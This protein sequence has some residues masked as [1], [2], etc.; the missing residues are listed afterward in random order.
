MWKMDAS[1]WADVLCIG[2][3]FELC[4]FGNWTLFN[5]CSSSSRT[6]ISNII[7]NI[8]KDDDGG[9][10]VKDVLSNNQM[11]LGIMQFA[12]SNDCVFYVLLLIC[13]CVCMRVY[14]CARSEC[15]RQS[16]FSCVELRLSW[17]IHQ[18]K[19]DC[20]YAYWVCWVARIPSQWKCHW[21]AIRYPV[22]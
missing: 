6:D 21:T 2:R 16:S 18:K 9:Q 13:V 22:K 14:A 1:M 8:K 4:G 3:E 20:I 17:L 7:M 15:V 12:C 19:V 10:K 11:H 5:G